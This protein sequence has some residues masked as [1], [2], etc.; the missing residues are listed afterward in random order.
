MGNKNYNK[1][2]HLELLKKKSMGIN[3]EEYSS[4]LG[5]Y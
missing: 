1:K 4:E 3:L 5:Q 2:R